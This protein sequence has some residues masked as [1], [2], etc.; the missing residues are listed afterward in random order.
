[1]LRDFALQLVDAEG[2]KITARQY[3][4]NSLREQKGASDAVEN[5]NRIRR[6]IKHFFK[7]RDCVTLVRPVEDERQLQSLADLPSSALRPE[8]LE[9]IGQLR[10][11][12]FKKARAKTL[13]GQAV[14]GPMLVELAQ[15]YVGALNGGQVPTIESA[16]DSVRASELDRGVREALARFDASLAEGYAHGPLA[17]KEERD[18][19]RRLKA[20][21][22]EH[23][24]RQALG[25]PGD[26]KAAAAKERLLAEIKRRAGVAKAKNLALIKQQCVEAL[27]RC[28]SQTIRAKL[29][30]YESFAGGLK[31][32]IEQLKGE[33][34]GSQF[35]ASP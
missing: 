26:A 25:D 3:L 4:E 17:E 27:D 5:K 8:F 14:S 18:V 30:Q 6:L 24:Q 1:M 9:Q 32:D 2:S 22:L 21:A 23:F 19:A 15:S 12:V 35:A 11:K 13:R 16:W 20:E 28:V 10:T 7:D 34:L 33:F 31:V 29:H